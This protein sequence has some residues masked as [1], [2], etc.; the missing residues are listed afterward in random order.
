VPP[1]TQRF[2]ARDND[3]HLG[4]LDLGTGRFTTLDAIPWGPAADNVVLASAFSADGSVVAWSAQQWPNQ[5][6]VT[7]HIHAV[8]TGT[9]TT[10]TVPHEHQ[11]PS[12]TIAPDGSQLVM[13]VNN[14]QQGL[15]TV[16]LREQP[17]LLTALTSPPSTCPG[18]D[19]YDFPVWTANG[20]FAQY[21]C[22][23]DSRTT[24][25]V[26]VRLDPQTGAQLDVASHLPRGGLDHFMVADGAGGPQFYFLPVLGNETQINTLH[27]LVGTHGRY[28]QLKDLTADH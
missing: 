16:R 17:M 27:E 28:R 24:A 8:T 20:L 26:V 21:N 19:T 2:V 9:H 25:A 10:L 14:T 7:V 1:A 12:M 23:N 3:V 6:T 13:R 4:Y 18:D 5:G 22:S 11:I 15:F